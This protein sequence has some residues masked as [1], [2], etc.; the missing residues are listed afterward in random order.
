MQAIQNPTRRLLMKKLIGAALICAMTASLISGCT[1]SEAV[2][3]EPSETAKWMSGRPQ[4]DFYYYANKETLDNAEFEYGAGYA[5]NAFDTTLIN[6]RLE[7]IIK[8]VVAGSGYEKGSEE[9]LIQTAYNSYVAYDF[10]NEP[11]PEELQQVIDEVKNA[12]SID[13]LMMTDA[14]LFRDFGVSGFFILNVDANPFLPEQNALAIAPYTSVLGVSFDDISEDNNALDSIL[15]DV[16][17]YLQTQGYDVDT[18]SDY[19][20][21]IANMALEICS[22]SGEKYSSDDYDNDDIVILYLSDCDDIFTNVDFEK[23]LMTIGFDRQGCEIFGT[24]NKEQLICVNS[25]LTDENLEALKAWEIGKIYGQYMRFIAPSYKLLSGYVTD[26]YKTSEEQAISEIKGSL[27]SETDPIYV[28]KYYSKEIDDGLRSM[29]DDIRESY[30]NLISSATWLSE[31]TRQ[32]LLEK[33]DNIVYVTGTDLKRHDAS[34]YANVGG[35]YFQFFLGYTRVGLKDIIASLGEPVDRY[36]VMMPMQTVNA[37][38]S[39]IKNNITITVAISGDS[40]F[41]VN[42]DYYVNLGNLGATIAHEMGHAFDSNC[43]VYDKDGAYNPGWIADEDMEALLAR[44]EKAVRYFE[45]NF[46]VFG[47]YHVDGEMTLG[48]NFADLSGME[49]LV[50]IPKTDEDMKKMLESYAR[51]YCRMSVDSYIVDQIASDVHSPEVIRVNAILS[52]VDVFYDVYD[53]QECDGMYIAPE[54]RISRW[55]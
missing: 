18:A 3:A 40:Y 17:V 13:E 2:T 35:N 27:Y 24:Y 26:N 10:A 37:C 45:D 28:E 4:D 46:T 30:R 25:L 54:N 5:A 52:T 32:G 14:K 44:N 53:V 20:K 22:S 16:R 11:V 42:G 15:S 51:S 7:N 49:C 8:D 31:P 48:E 47:I 9:Y 38:Y 12:N 36:E 1:P 50:L 41:D 23:Y 6:E 19:G 29:C 55:H 39:P 43:I 33:L 34:K 21:Q